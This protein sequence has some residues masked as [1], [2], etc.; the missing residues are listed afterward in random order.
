MTH[1]VSMV[2]V[3]GF[4]LDSDLWA[5]FE[6]GLS[7]VGEPRFA[8]HH[9]DLSQDATIEAMAARLLAGAPRHFVL[10][11][12]SLGGYVARQAARMAPE[13]V[14]ALILIATSSEGDSEIQ[15]QRK[16]AVARSF[17]PE[18]FA[19]LSRAAVLPSV[20]AAHQHG[21][22]IARI[23]AMGH[24]LGGQ[25]F[26]RQSALVRTSDVDQLGEIPCPTLIIAGAEDGLRSLD[27]ATVLHQRI[28]QSTLRVIAGSGH[29]I[30]LEAPESL[31]AIVKPWLESLHLAD[32]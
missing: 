18:R 24:R 5:E 7:D 14:L 6:A 9:A 30:P 10:I 22:I 15:R 4:M 29:M 13:R 26:Q 2:L 8:V 27:E 21:P 20:A 12:F 16:Q 3:P 11:G 32:A 25:V 1:P 28:P 17:D 19:G 23:Q 31:L